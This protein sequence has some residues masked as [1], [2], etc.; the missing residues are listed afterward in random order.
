MKKKKEN[1]IVTLLDKRMSSNF[2]YW[3]MIILITL[4]LS[5]VVFGIVA[6]YYVVKNAMPSAQRFYTEFAL[7]AAAALVSLIFTIRCFIR[8][9][10]SVAVMLAAVVAIFLSFCVRFALD[11]PYVSNPRTTTLHN[12]TMDMEIDYWGDIVVL[13][14]MLYGYDEE[15]KKHSLK[16]DGNDYNDYR[17]RADT[18]VISYL[19]HSHKIMNIDFFQTSSETTPQPKPLRNQLAGSIAAFIFIKE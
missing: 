4:S 15:G 3:L 7:C 9:K 18:A 11:V 6:L 2:S 13:D 10:R 19:P 16:I 5:A 14:Y 8:H 17:S 1:P 12:I